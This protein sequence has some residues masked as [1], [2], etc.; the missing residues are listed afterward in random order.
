[1]AGMGGAGTARMLG[2]SHGRQPAAARRKHAMPLC[3]S[4]PRPPAVHMNVLRVWGGGIYQ[5]D[6]FYQACDRLG[7]MVWQEA[8]FA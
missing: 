1:M 4:P 2:A 8:M 5:P 3:S 7:L 6:A